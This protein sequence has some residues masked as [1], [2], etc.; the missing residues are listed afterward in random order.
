MLKTNS[1]A[2]KEAVKA[3]LIECAE[4]EDLATI[5]DLKERFLKE[6]SW[7]IPRVGL[8]EAFIDW[9]QGLA[10]GCV[11]SYYDIVRV[12]AK[13]LDDTIENQEK[14]LDKN[15]DRLYWY[16]MAREIINAK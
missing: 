8:Q 14:Q 1:K 3:Y 9:L 13:W 16:L 4:T 12:L 7:E 10:I 15:G 11:Y 6:K 2:V 5:S